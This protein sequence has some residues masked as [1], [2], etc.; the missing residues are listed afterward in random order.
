MTAVKSS[1]LMRS[2]RPSRVT[3]AFETSTST[4]SPKCSV[5]SAKAAS[6]SSRGRDVAG[7]PEQPVGRLGAAVGDGD[8]VA[9]GVEPAGDGEADAP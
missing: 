7:H 1:S 6:T 5:T 9:V 2:S 8:P 4:G 3:P